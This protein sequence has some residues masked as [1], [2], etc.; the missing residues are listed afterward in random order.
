MRRLPVLVG[1]GVKSA[2]LAHRGDDVDG[3]G[4]HVQPFDFEGPELAGAQAA[5]GAEEDRGAIAVVDRRRER[6]HLL[7]RQEVHLLAVAVGRDLDLRERRSNDEEVVDGLREHLGG[8][9]RDALDRRRR[10]AGRDEVGDEAPGVSRPHRAHRHV[11]EERSSVLVDPPFDVQLR[12]R[13][14]VGLRR[15]P[16][17]DV[18]AA[19]DLAERR[20]GQLAARMAAVPGSA[21]P[22][23]PPA[24]PA[25]GPR[26]R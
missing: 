9:E 3:A 16:A 12:R 26:G 2:G 4:E 1:P 6:V 13:R 8:R 5:V 14:D 15:E 19:R 20:L 11:R 17:V 21:P 22:A 23:A 18:V 7:G 10:E 24:R 25:R